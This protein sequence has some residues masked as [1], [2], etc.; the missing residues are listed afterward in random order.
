MFAK[1][2]FNRDGNDMTEYAVIGAVV[3]LVALAGFQL[4]GVNILGTIQNVA[5]AI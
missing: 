2:F 5:G 4:L 1:F 3:L